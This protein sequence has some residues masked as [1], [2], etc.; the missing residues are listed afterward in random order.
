MANKQK[1][2]KLVPSSYLVLIKNNKILLL[3]RI[4]TGFQ[5]GKYGLVAGHVEKN[6]GF[7][8]AM[9]R[10]AK[11]EANIVLNSKDL[12]VAHVLN[13]SE[14]KNKD[15][16]IKERIDVFFIAKKWQGEI[17]NM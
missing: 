15:V 8:K 6:E 14:K 17:K 12:E 4:N 1:R 13:R 5:D 10:E 3:R 7:T 9:I 2:F 16:E 11:E